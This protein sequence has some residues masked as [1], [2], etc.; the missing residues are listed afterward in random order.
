MCYNSLTIL[1]CQKCQRAPPPGIQEP[2]PRHCSILLLVDALL[3][4]RQGRVSKHRLQSEKIL[5]L[6]PIRFSTETPLELSFTPSPI[7]RP[8]S[9]PPPRSKRIS[10]FS[11][12][13][14]Q[15]MSDCAGAVTAVRHLRALYSACIRSR[16]CSFD[17][18]R[19]ASSLHSDVFSSMN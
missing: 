3:C 15:N 12:I 4:Q 8:R 16:S 2:W 11:L 5:D 19:S 7:F 14:H 6:G 18:G 9:F 13:L 10:G 17:V 1:L